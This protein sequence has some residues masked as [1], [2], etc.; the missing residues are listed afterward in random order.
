MQNCGVRFADRFQSFPKEI[1][2]FCILHSSFCIHSPVLINGVLINERTTLFIASVSA[3]YIF[4]GALKPSRPMLV[5]STFFARPIR[6]I[7][8]ALTVSSSSLR[9]G[10]S[11]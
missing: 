3:A 6:A 11:W 8:P 7:W 2:S 10:V 5:S 9:M 1:P 4:S